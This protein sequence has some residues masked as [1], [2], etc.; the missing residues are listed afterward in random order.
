[1][2]KGGTSAS[3]Q[4]D[5]E[6]RLIERSRKKKTHAL[7]LKGEG[8]KARRNHSS[9]QRVKKR[10]EERLLEKTANRSRSER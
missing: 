7:A 9:C 4:K 1:M 2:K 5:T 10:E 8:K 3:Q 6:R